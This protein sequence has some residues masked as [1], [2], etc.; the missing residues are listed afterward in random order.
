[1]RKTW[2][3]KGNLPASHVGLYYA[4]HCSILSLQVSKIIHM[5]KKNMRD[6][7]RLQ[8]VD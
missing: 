8:D 4:Y 6:K 7:E 2:V 5:L 3:L 1:M